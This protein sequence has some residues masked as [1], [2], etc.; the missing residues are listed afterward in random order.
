VS[1]LDANYSYMGTSAD[2]ASLAAFRRNEHTTNLSA[3]SLP[4][5][6]SIID[7]R[8]FAQDHPDKLFPLLAN[9]RPEFQELFIEYYVLGKSQSFLAKVH[10]QIQTRIWQN[11]R[12]I[13]NALGALI[14]LGPTPSKGVMFK[15]LGRVGMDYTEYGSLA[16]LIALYAKSQNYAAVAEAVDAQVPAIRKIF[17]PAI[18]R[19]L[20]SRDLEAVAIGCYLRSLTHQASL[21]GK[22]LSKRC[23][24]RNN[25]VKCLRYTAPAMDASALLEFGAVDSLKDAPWNMFEISS[26]HRMDVIFPSLRKQGKEIFGKKGGQIFAPLDANGE[27][28]LCYILARSL[29]PKLTRRLTHIRGISEMAGSYNSEDVLTRAESVPNADVQKLIA[30]RCN[31]KV[32]QVK[33]GDF[34]K[35][36]TGGAEAYCG[37]VTASKGSRLIVEVNFPSNRQFIVTADPSAL[38]R[39]HHVPGHVRAFWGFSS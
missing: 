20:R 7:F 38:K 29:S 8:T 12:I 3:E 24:A 32:Q 1:E 17:R 22:G 39:I 13:E 34:V 15:I 26:E 18:E 10:G 23:I 31:P 35:I 5:N 4:E 21:T 33:V 6:S 2:N 27:L 19:L 36:L 28:E 25:R 11:L 16:N 30:T 37:S 9:L 14:V